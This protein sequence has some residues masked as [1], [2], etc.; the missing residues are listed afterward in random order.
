MGIVHW[1]LPLLVVPLIS[2]THP[3]G[4]PPGYRG[5]SRCGPATM[6]MV[7]RG[8]H[9]K[10]RLS[11]A[12]LIDM[13]DRLDDGVVNHATTPAGMVRMADALGLRARMRNGFDGAWVRNT[14]RKGGLVIALG[15]P[16]FLPA[17]EAHTKGHFVSIIGV[18]RDGR[19]IVNDAYRRTAKRGTRYRVTEATLASFVRHKPNG[20]LFAIHPAP[21]TLAARGGM[22]AARPH[23]ARL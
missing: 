14:L 11:D 23:H 12:Q 6:A 20:M 16:R 18:A 22:R 2:Q 7:A 13:L 19:L 9:K 17:T 5:E 1:L 8:F 10:P 15:R 21:R 4:R 3:R